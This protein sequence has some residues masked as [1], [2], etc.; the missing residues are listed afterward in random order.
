M[1]NIISETHAGA[2]LLLVRVSFL[3]SL[4]MVVLSA[5]IRLSSINVECDA[6]AQCMATLALPQ[7]GHRLSPSGVAGA[8]HRIVATVFGVLVLALTYAVLR[9]RRSGRVPVPAAL[10][11]LG[12]TVF[13]S[14]LGFSTPAP[15]TPAVT[16]GNL[17]GGMAITALLWWMM[18]RTALR[19]ARIPGAPPPVLRGLVL[20][21]LVALSIQIV[22]GA[23]TSANLAGA[24]CPSLFDC[25]AHAWGAGDLVRAFDPTRRLSVSPDHTATAD[26]YAALVQLVHRLCA[27]LATGILLA[28]G[29]VA[30]RS[31]A[32][33]RVTAAAILG[34]L[35]LQAAGGMFT[36]LH[37]GSHL[38]ATLHNAVSVLLL[39]AVVD[40]TLLTRVAPVPDDQAAPVPGNRERA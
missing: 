34:L 16:V 32:A 37:P 11:V 36:A 21:G 6:G 5:H 3:L 29:I 33:Y 15:T 1:P 9:R 25:G 13:L 38:L 40:L 24:A 27:I 35:A 2:L 18:R 39:L 4:L 31:H 10:G 30:T 14:V 12:I 23:W 26:Q 17:A 28:A 22:L 19:D 8:A 20:A 7:A